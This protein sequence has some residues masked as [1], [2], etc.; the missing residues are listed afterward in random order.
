MYITCGADTKH[1]RYHIH[2]TKW[3]MSD[4]TNRTRLQNRQQTQ[5]CSS[6]HRKLTA[7]HLRRCKTKANI[8][9][10]VKS[11]NFVSPCIGQLTYEPRPNPRHLLWCNNVPPVQLFSASYVQHYVNYDMIRDK[12]HLYTGIK[13]VVSMMLH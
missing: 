1:C 8:S 5:T 2:L 12:S 13:S 6:C 9:L 10:N 3:A 11:A 4:P 7:F